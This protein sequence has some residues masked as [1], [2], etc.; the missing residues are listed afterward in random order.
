MLGKYK[1]TSIP[2]KPYIKVKKWEYMVVKPSS[3]MEVA[4][5]ER[6]LKPYTLLN[7][8]FSKNEAIHTTYTAK[9]KIKTT[10]SVNNHI[11]LYSIT[12]KCGIEDN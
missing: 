12:S 4:D 3:Y 2:L 5:L 11:V 1:I 7:Y 6:K 10:D 8:K 9:N